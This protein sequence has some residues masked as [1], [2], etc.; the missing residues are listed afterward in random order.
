MSVL[1]TFLEGVGLGFI[2]PLIE[3]AQN[4][5]SSPSDTEGSLPP[6]SEYIKTA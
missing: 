6:S 2:V 1:V 3:F 5:N 4:P